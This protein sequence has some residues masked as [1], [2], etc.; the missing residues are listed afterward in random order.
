MS[1]QESKGQRRP[2]IFK[3][4]KPVIA[5]LITDL[6]MKVIYQISFTFTVLQVTTFFID[7]NPESKIITL[8]IKTFFKQFGTG[9][10]ENRGSEAP[11]WN[12]PQVNMFISLDT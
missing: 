8:K 6:L 4:I 11:V 10:T 12:V 1:K 7:Y 3:N 9:A 5:T 2:F